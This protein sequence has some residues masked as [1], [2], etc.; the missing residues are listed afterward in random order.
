MNV[1]AI[2]SNPELMSE[3]TNPGEGIKPWDKMLLGLSLLVFVAT[4]ILAGLDSGRYQLSM[5]VPWSVVALGMFFMISGQTIFLIARKENKFF[6]TVMRIQKERGHTV[7][8][9]GIYR[10]IRHP[11]YLGMIISTIVFH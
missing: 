10:V 3:R 4:M 1:L 8:E 11:G 2:K 7:C 6:S 5:H 9:S